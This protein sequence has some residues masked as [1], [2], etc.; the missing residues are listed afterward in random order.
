MKEKITITPQGSG[1]TIILEGPC[2]H[3]QIVS[4]CKGHMEMNLQDR[5]E[6]YVIEEN[7]AEPKIRKYL[8]EINYGVVRV[9]KAKL[10]TQYVVGV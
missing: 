10:K 1:D 2:D 4:V 3:S 9:L 7:V 6:F 5:E 8:I